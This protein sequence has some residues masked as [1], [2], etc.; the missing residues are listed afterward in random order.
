MGTGPVVA[1][2]AAPV[3]SSRT[4]MGAIVYDGGV[5]FRVWAKFASSVFVVGDFNGW[6]TAA[7][8]LAADGDSGYWSVDVPGAVAGQQYQFFI[9]GAPNGGY[10]MDP[11]AYQIGRSSVGLNAVV[12]TY[13]T[14]YVGAGFSTPK[15]N[16]AV[17]Y[18]LHIPT[19]STAAG[20]SAG[21]L[22]TALTRLPDLVDLGINAIEI[23]PLGE[24][25]TLTSSGYNPGYIFAV[26]DTYG[27]PDEFRDFVNQSH[28][29][30]V[31]VILDVVYNHLGVTDLWQ[32]DGWYLPD[33]VCPYGD[34]A[35]TQGGI[36]FYQDNRAHTDFA[37]SRFD[38]GRAEVQQ[39]LVD[40]AMRWLQDRYVD[41]LRFDS[42]VNIRG[43]QVGGTIV[44]DI[45]D[46]KALLC[47]INQELQQSQPWKLTVAEDLQGWSAI[48]APVD[49]GGFGFGAQWDNDLCFALR[50]AVLPEDDGSRQVGTV[51]NSIAAI[52]GELAFQNVVYTENHDRDDKDQGGGRVPDLISPGASDSW[53][54]KKRSTLAAAVVMTV[55][56][57]PMIFQG[58][59]FLTWAP[60]PNG[61]GTP[62]PLDWNGLRQ[63]F[64]GIRSLYRDL[65]HLR[66]NWFNNTRGLQGANTHVLPVF[67]DNMLVYHRWDQGGAG[68]DV[69]VVCNFAN[70]GYAGYAIGLPRGGTW[71][72][73]FN[74]DAGAYDEFFGNWSSF[75]TVADGPALNGMPCSGSVGIGP[76][77]CVILSQD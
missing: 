29:L 13:D 37:H 74:S 70:Q 68:D 30:G 43:V 63:Q 33:V 38:F 52:S 49:S 15:W 31:G 71:C 7:N 62:T 21:T 45:S 19:F 41:G 69:V 35:A 6:N 12:A 27:G 40:N 16:E 75:D 8:P 10:R 36:Y 32:I 14:A 72:V 67:A 53:A 64:A 11:Y 34:N 56:G 24:F 65:I 42:V 51:A 5:T 46:G 9:P 57:I 18:E 48:T 59:E 50:N 39:Y 47:R 25:E 60:F 22:D 66:R 73:R 1:A 58:Q 76:Y 28:A 55:P 26:E 2:P 20:G 17:L 44:C 61:E 4:G 23:M 77:S 3:S 54:A